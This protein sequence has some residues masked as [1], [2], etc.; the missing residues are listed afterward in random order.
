M[1]VTPSDAH[2]VVL[3]V[4]C[5][6]ERSRLD[7]QAFVDFVSGSADFSVLFVNDGEHRRNGGAPG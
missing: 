5:Y 7:L 4:P 6:N 2:G 1:S 3:V